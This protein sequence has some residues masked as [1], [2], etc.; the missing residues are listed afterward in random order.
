MSWHTHNDNN[1]QYD[2]G[3][4]AVVFGALMMLV[5]TLHSCLPVDDTRSLDKTLAQYK[6]PRGVYADASVWILTQ[7]DRK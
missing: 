4:W 2:C 5:V 6:H 3:D 1:R 7:G